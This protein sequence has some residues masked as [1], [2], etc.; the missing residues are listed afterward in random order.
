MSCYISLAQRDAAV[1]RADGDV[2]IRS[3]AIS[4]QLFQYILHQYLV[5]EGPA[6]ESHLG[7]LVLCTGCKALL[8]Y[9]VGYPL[10]KRQSQIRGDIFPRVLAGKCSSVLQHD[11]ALSFVI[12]VVLYTKKSGHSV[13]KPSHA[14]AVYSIDTCRK[15]GHDDAV[16]VSSQKALSAVVDDI[17]DIDGDPARKVV[18]G[19]SVVIVR[20]YGKISVVEGIDIAESRAAGILNGRIAAY[21]VHIFQVC[22][23]LAVA[24]FAYEEFASPYGTVGA[25]AGA[26]EADSDDFALYIVFSHDRRYMGVMVLNLYQGKIALGSV[27][28][29][30]S[31]GVVKRVHV[32][33]DDIGGYPEEVLETA[34]VFFI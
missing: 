12:V 20:P 13:E 33:D 14:G 9:H 17:G 4:P 8:Q 11:G 10:M 26:V 1:I 15:G 27:P 7:D 31:G 3:E 29:G 30:E 19:K 16:I 5:L 18:A 24:A 23:A 32:A 22:D 21:H 28:F 2:V 34:Y 6:G 25:V